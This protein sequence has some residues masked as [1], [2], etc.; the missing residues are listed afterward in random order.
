MKKICI[1]LIALTVTLSVQGQGFYFR[2]GGGYGLPAAT[3][4]IGQ[5]VL[6]DENATTA[7]PSN[8]FSTKVITGSFGSGIN[9]KIGAGYEFTQNFIFAFDIQYLGGKKYE[10][11]D[12]YNYTTDTYTGTSQDVSESSA[13]GV[14]FNPSFVFSAGFGKAAP[15]GRFGL[16]TGSPRVTKTE[17]FFDNLDGTTTGDRTWVYKNGLAIGYSAG[18]GMNW[19]IK[20]NLDFYTEADFTGLTYYAKEA[21]LTKSIYNGTDNLSQMT[22]AQTKI[23]FLKQYDPTTPYDAAK[24]QLAARTGSPFSSFALEV[25][26]R[27]TLVKIKD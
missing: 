3:T 24:P 1:A 6:H 16:V 14:L 4:Q 11:N 27:F 26:I 22:V 19:K 21:D 25:G 10:T 13:T 9:L 12:M 18:I 15:Y 7:N 23:L 20:D 2:V 5:Q 17:S 8:T